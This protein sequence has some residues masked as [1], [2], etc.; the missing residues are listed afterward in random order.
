M[1]LV[2]VGATSVVKRAAHP[3]SKRA[4]LIPAHRTQPSTRGLDDVGSSNAFDVAPKQLGHSLSGAGAVGGFF[5]R[6][7]AAITGMATFC[8]PGVS[9]LGWRF[10]N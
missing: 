4:A 5:D 9:A 10:F 3:L 6:S 1:K 8:Q 7:V 2:C